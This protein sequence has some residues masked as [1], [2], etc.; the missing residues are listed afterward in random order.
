MYWFDACRTAAPKN[1]QQVLYV[2]EPNILSKNG[3]MSPII[4][5]PFCTIIALPG[6]GPERPET[7]RR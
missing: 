5:H 3:T 6:D 7:W 2:Q 1:F 4:K